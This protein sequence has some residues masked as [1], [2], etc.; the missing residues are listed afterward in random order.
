MIALDTAKTVRF[1]SLRT[2]QREIWEAVSKDGK[3]SFR[4][5]EERGTPWVVYHSDFPGWS[6]MAAS[7]PKAR[8]Y[9]EA[10]LHLDLTTVAR[11]HA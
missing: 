8:R 9:A 4:R 2:G 3:W 6:M 10:Q 1:P 5:L 7:L 11:G